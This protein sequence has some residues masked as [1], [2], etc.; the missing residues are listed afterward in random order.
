MSTSEKHRQIRVDADA[1]YRLNA[2]G[3][4]LKYCKSKNKK[5]QT[6]AVGAVTFAVRVPKIDRSS[7]D[8]HRVMCV[9]VEKL[10][11]KQYLYRL[12]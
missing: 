9:I 12:K 3:M 8:S 10:G 7:T 11:R 2:E 1:R 6:F 4:Q 5:I